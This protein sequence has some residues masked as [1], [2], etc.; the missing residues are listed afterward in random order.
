VIHKLSG[1][2][3]LSY[4]TWIAGCGSVGNTGSSDGTVK[5]LL[6][7]AGWEEGGGFASLKADIDPGG[8]GLGFPFGSTSYGA[9]ELKAISVWNRE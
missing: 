4:G 1:L 3:A 5:T 6:V 9:N 8:P 2:K 7:D